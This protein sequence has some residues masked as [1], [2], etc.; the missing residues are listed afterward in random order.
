MEAETV[1]STKP[2]RVP[3]G[4]KRKQKIEDLT[5]KISQCNDL[6]VDTKKNYLESLNAVL[7]TRKM[8][9]SS[10]AYLK[11]QE[12]KMSVK[13]TQYTKEM[14]KI[15]AMRREIGRQ[16]E[17]DD[18]KKNAIVIKK[19]CAAQKKHD[20]RTGSKFDITRLDRMPLDVVLYIG[21]FLTHEVQTQYLEDVYNP[22]SIFNKLKVNTKRYFLQLALEDKKYF[23][24][25]STMEMVKASERLHSAGYNTINEE[26][27]A[28]IH[29]AKQKNPQGAHK[30]IKAMCMLFK[31]NKKY[32]A[33]WHTFSTAKN[34]LRLQRLQ[35]IQGN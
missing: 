28:L 25:L 27:S 1:L 15:Q 26:I 23:S 12:E 19:E 32:N 16:L 8:L 5:Y 22:F 14:N 34:K 6:L 11:N 18:I 2:R 24:H 4:E 17:V 9:K 35:E 33:N 13:E 10:K 21:E 29:A 7:S 30:L 3:A 31:K 20:E